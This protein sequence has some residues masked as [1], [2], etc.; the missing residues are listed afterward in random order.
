MVSLIQ[1]GTAANEQGTYGHH[2]GR[3]GGRRY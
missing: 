1:E 2:G 3:G